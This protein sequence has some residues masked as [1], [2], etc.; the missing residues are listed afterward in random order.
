ML[1]IPLGLSLNKIAYQSYVAK[2]VQLEI[3]D[4]FNDTVSRISNFSI[5]FN[6]KDEIGVECIMITDTYIRVQR[7]IFKKLYMKKLVYL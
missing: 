6:N 3:E 5:N 2:T 4:R 7:K 1:S